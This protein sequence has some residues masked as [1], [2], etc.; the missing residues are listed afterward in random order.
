MGTKLDGP[1]HPKVGTYNEESEAQRK[2]V[3]G[4]YRIQHN[5]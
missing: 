1:T 3:S 4:D 2:E 5:K